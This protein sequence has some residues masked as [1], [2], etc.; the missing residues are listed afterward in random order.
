M[1]EHSDTAYLEI[2]LSRIRVCKD[3]RPKFG[4][5]SR[6]GLTYE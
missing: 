1:I 3:Y 2:I 6:S 4:Q 5:P